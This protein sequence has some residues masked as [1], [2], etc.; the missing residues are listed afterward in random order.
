MSLIITISL[1]GT[2]IFLVAVVFR[3]RVIQGFINHGRN[4]C[5]NFLRSRLPEKLR[6]MKDDEETESEQEAY[7]EDPEKEVHELP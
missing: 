3:K 1:E 2:L 5:I 7:S 6:T 4:S